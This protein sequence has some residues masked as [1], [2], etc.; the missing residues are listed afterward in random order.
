M[1]ADE[2]A[3]GIPYSMVHSFVDHLKKYELGV[4]TKAKRE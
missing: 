3:C 2:M 4:M 1:A